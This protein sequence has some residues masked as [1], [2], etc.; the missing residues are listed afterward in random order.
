[1]YVG[2]SL[3][4]GQP[5]LILDYSKSRLWPDVRDEEREV[6]PGLYLGIMYRGE[7]ADGAEDVL[8][9]WTRGS[10]RIR[11]VEERSE[12]LADNLHQ[13]RRNSS[14]CGGYAREGSSVRS[15]DVSTS[16]RIS[17]GL[18][19]RESRRYRPAPA[20]SDRC[21]RR[22]RR[23]TAE[24]RVEHVTGDDND[25]LHSARVPRP[26]AGPDRPL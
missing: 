5:A 6:S 3:L 4:D 18:T 7:V 13:I 24:L 11:E 16:P 1:M 20:F 21:R 19:S 10:S 14:L 2:E 12:A 17:A 8:H 15:W 26:S 23:R 22:P 9:A 25:R